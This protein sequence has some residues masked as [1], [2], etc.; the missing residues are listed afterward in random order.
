V[1]Q[2]AAR[3]DGER[4]GA[5]LNYAGRC[6]KVIDKFRCTW[7]ATHTEYVSVIPGDPALRHER[8]DI[9]IVLC[10]KHDEEFQRSGLLGVVTAYGDEIA[11]CAQ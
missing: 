10:R 11:E 8:H 3:A 7:T 5:T 9:D 4:T 1:D 6:L 2:S